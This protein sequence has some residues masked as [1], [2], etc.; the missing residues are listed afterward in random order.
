MNVIIPMAGAGTRMED[1]LPKFMLNA[2]GKPM[3]Q[4]VIDSLDIPTAQYVFV[5][6][7]D[8]NVGDVSDWIMTRI[9]ISEHQKQIVTVKETRGPAETAYLATPWVDLRQPLIIADCDNFFTW[10][11]PVDYA[12]EN[13]VLCHRINSYNDKYSYVVPK[14]HTELRGLELTKEC[15]GDRILASAGVYGWAKGEVFVQCF[16]RM[17]DNQTSDTLAELLMLN[18]YQHLPLLDM[19]FR[20]DIVDNYH[21][22]GNR[23]DLAEFNK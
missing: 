19:D 9:S 1:P 17:L 15:Y 21:N 12:L 2:K 4:Q 3:V 22:L 10:N 23:L 16:Q 11:K 18:V 14:K 5:I 8:Y 20:C 6:R 13:F 7:D